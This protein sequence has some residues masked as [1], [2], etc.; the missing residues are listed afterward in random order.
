MGAFTRVGPGQRRQAML[1]GRAHQLVVGRVKLHQVDA[2]TIAVMATE[3]RRVLVGQKPRRH[4]WPAGQRPVCIN[5]RLG[6]TRPVTSRPLLQRQID[7]VEVGAI[8]RWR[9]VGDLMGFS[10]LVQVHRGAS[11]IRT[12]LKFQ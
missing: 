5:A 6:P 11:W 1:D 3:L 8:Q 10:V 9:L 4:Q 2:V 7:A 12:C